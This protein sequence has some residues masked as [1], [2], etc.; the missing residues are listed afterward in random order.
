MEA[1]ASE[2]LEKP[3]PKKVL[4]EAQLANL[5]KGRARKREIQAKTV[6]EKETKKMEDRFDKLLQM[7]EAIRL[8]PPEVMEKKVKAKPPPVEEDEVSDEEPAPK[9]KRIE[10]PRVKAIAQPDTKQIFLRFC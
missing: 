2:P 4:S 9:P 7:F 6:E 1:E 8:P 3:R 5:E 10:K